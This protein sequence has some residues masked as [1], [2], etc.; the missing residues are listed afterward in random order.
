MQ[1]VSAGV[2]S[3]LNP[4]GNVKKLERQLQFADTFQNRVQLADA[5]LGTGQ[6]QKAVSLYEKSLTGNFSENEHILQQLI[7][8]YYDEQRF[9]DVITAAGKIYKQPQFNR[10]RAHIY[11]ALSLE[12]TGNLQKA[13]EEFKKLGGYFSQ[14]EARYQYAKF[15]QRHQ[16][17]G[18]ADKL[19]K[20]ML[21]EESHL[22]PI[23]KRDNRYWLNMVKQELKKK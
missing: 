3:I 6:V 9:N 1:N 18:E 20:E 16:R 8:A 7:L 12:K 2:S 17:Q 15:L 5:Y 4:G 21:G 23:E 14:Y 10:S 11:Y 13:E 22:G 19:L